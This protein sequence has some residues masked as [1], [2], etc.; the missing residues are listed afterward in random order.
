MIEQAAVVTA[1]SAQ[2][3]LTGAYA[4]V[5][6]TQRPNLME[7]GILAAIGLLVSRLRWKATDRS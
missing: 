3:A 2:T 5:A 1:S 6:V 4:T 7:L